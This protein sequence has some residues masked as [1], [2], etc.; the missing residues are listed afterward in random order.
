VARAILVE[1]VQNEAGGFVSGKS[2][3]VYKENGV[4]LFDQVM[5]ASA[6]SSTPLANPVTSG[7]LGRLVL[8][9]DQPARVKLKPSGVTS[10]TDSEFKV[11][12]A[13]LAILSGGTIKADG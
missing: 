7:S 8:Y 13:S 11:D 6:T 2:I 4:T 12:Q 10:L 9:C 3:T 5:Y 1:S